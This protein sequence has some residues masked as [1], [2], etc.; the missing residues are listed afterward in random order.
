[1]RVGLIGAGLQARRRAPAIRS[2]LGSELVVISA[3]YAESAQSAALAKSFG[4]ESTDGWEN[5]VKRNDLDA[6]VICTPP[7]L[8]AKIGL[9]AMESGKHVLCEK[10]LSRT[11]EEAEA[12]VKAANVNNVKLKCGLNHRFHPAIQKAKQLL[13]SEIGEPN[14]VRCRYGIGGRPGF[15]KEWR[16]N[17][18]IAGGGE[19]MDQGTHAI[20]LS[21]W[22]LGEFIEVSA[23]M[24]NY[25]PNLNLVEDNGFVLLRTKAGQVASIHASLTQWK[26]L[27]SFEVF[28]SEGYVVAE[29]LGGSYGNECLTF[30]RKDFA[31]PFAE[32]VVEF[33]GD[34]RSWCE[35]WKEFVACIKE[36]REPLANGYDGL[37]AMRIVSAVYKAAG[38]RCVV[39]L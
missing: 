21:R 19:M 12:L 26:N 32:E 23:F 1:M 7:H 30:G 10:P 25:L 11:V 2:S 34:D 38:G 13:L 9:A 24:A 28:G 20:D 36:D 8:H 16:A 18:E 17:P 29:G 39:S 37:V 15:E 14:F 31:K 4:C 27:F 3:D 35:E 5:V 33:R 6:V 22:F